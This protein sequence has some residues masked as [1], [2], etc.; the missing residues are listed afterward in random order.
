MIKATP[1][2]IRMMERMFFVLRIQCMA[3]FLRILALDD[4]AKLEGFS[5]R[6][7]PSGGRQKELPLTGFSPSCFTAGLIGGSVRS[8]NL[9]LGT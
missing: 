3:Y 5:S 7:D 6:S 1:E 4:K 9:K 2:A 8:N